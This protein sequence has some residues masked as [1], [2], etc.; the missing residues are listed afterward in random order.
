MRK[1]EAGHVPAS[2]MYTAPVA[3]YD[4]LLCTGLI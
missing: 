1:P 4:Q 2:I 3:V